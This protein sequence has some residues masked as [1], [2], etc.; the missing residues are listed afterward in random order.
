MT[1]EE[2][3]VLT[4]DGW[5]E[6]YP[7][8]F[9]SDEDKAHLRVK[10]GDDRYKV[11]VKPEASDV[12]EEV[13]SADTMIDAY[14]KAEKYMKTHS[15][16]KVSKDLHVGWEEKE[17]NRLWYDP[18]NK[19]YL[20]VRE[21]EWKPLGLK[22]PGEAPEWFVET[23]DEGGDWKVIATE[24]NEAYAYTSA[25]TYMRGGLEAL[26]KLK[27]KSLEISPTEK[28]RAI[29]KELSDKLKAF[30]ETPEGVRVIEKYEKE[31]IDHA[32]EMLIAYMDDWKESNA[33][34]S[35]LINM[36]SADQRKVFGRELN[37]AEL[38]ELEVLQEN[39]GKVND[40][41]DASIG[42]LY[43]RYKALKEFGWEAHHHS[44]VP[45]ALGIGI[46]YFLK[47]YYE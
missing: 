9:W 41:L 29:H 32:K 25:L 24:P 45:I 42:K 10:Y 19:Q 46:L 44:L 35:F 38:K 20:R 15:P 31:E 28:F 11:E 40:D 33:L 26:R 37:E 21:S 30:L 16:P 4:V 43:A 2:P 7:G 22:T 8:M 18:E 23:K 34:A 47:R 27:G 6:V 39:A 13:D 36:S 1:D 12:W 14:K 3:E 5:E 17:M